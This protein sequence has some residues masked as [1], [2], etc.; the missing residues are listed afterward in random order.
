M[1]C[2]STAIIIKMSKCHYIF[3]ILNASLLAIKH[4]YQLKYVELR[5][6]Y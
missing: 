4:S 1:V 5:I 6:V 3:F 2:K